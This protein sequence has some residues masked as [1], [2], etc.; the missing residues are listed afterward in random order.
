MRNS[1]DTTFWLDKHTSLMMLQAGDVG[2]TWDF[3]D[4]F[5]II[6]ENTPSDEGTNS[7]ADFSESIPADGIHTV[8]FGAF[9]PSNSALE[10][11]FS[12]TGILAISVLIFASEDIDDDG[13]QGGDPKYSQ[14]MPFQAISTK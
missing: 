2:G 10:T 3:G 14:N 12:E 5:Y 7:Y 11:I 4:T 6:E 8:Y 9:R 13:Y 1:D